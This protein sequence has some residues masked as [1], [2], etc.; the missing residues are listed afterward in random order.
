MEA[1]ARI[2]REE[3]QEVQQVE[4]RYSNLRMGLQM[5]E[6]REVNLEKIRKRRT[7]AA[8]EA[9]ANRTSVLVLRRCCMSRKGY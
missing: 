3:H 2:K 8:D 1:Q 6:Q 5:Q 4:R 7:L 9:S